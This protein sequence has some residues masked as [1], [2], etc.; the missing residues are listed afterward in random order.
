MRKRRK[1]F[2]ASASHPWFPT[3]DNTT[4]PNRPSQRHFHPALTRHARGN[5]PR[6]RWR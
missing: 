4:T 1:F 2:I 3:H 6:P 5:V